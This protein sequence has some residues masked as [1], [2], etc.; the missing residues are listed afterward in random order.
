MHPSENKQKF[1]ELKASMAN[2]TS[3]WQCMQILFESITDKYMQITQMSST[4]ESYMIKVTNAIERTKECDQIQNIHPCWKHEQP[5]I[6]LKK[7]STVPNLYIDLTTGFQ[8]YLY[9]MKDQEFISSDIEMSYYCQILF[10][11]LYLIGTCGGYVYGGFIRD[12][13]VFVTIY[14][15][16]PNHPNFKDIDIW[17]SNEADATK[18]VSLLQD[19]PPA[20][21][22]ADSGATDFCSEY[23]C[24]QPFTRTK[25][26][27]WYSHVSLFLIDIIVAEQIP[28]NDFAVNLLMFKAE[29]QNMAEINEQWFHVGNNFDGEWVHYSVNN[30]ICSIG[31]KKTDVLKTYQIPRLIDHADYR[32]IVLARKQKM[33]DNKW[34][35]SHPSLSE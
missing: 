1:S 9:R 16:S 19:L 5:E 3:H 13:L 2:L 14:G 17:F 6:F 4:F 24:G 23:G 20:K 8:E 34:T 18:F 31:Q 28:V 11:F 15:I 29:S 22:V 27:F 21:M 35:L 30:L 7:I 25:Y 33:I 32:R 26:H 10:N 12:F